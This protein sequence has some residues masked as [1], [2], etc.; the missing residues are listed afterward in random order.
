MSCCL[1]HAFLSFYSK[2]TGWIGAD[3]VRHRKSSEYAKTIPAA[4]MIFVLMDRQQI[5]CL[6][7]RFHFDNFFAIIKPASLA[8]LVR[9]FFRM[10]L[11]AVDQ[12]GYA[13]FPVRPGPAGSGL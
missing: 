10:T 3:S 9:H 8:D 7:L 13:Q 2:S 5:G 1:L 4:S 11:R 6:F 12:T